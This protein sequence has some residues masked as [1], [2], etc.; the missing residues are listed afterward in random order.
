MN[1]LFLV[2]FFNLPVF[3]IFASTNFIFL[4]QHLLTSDC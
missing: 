1:T 3:S 4:H 2:F